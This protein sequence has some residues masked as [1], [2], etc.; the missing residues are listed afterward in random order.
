MSESDLKGYDI[1]PT[2]L[3]PNYPEGYDCSPITSPYATWIDVDGTERNAQHSGIDLGRLN[4]TII[5][6][7]PGRVKAVWRANWGWGLEGA[8]L[9]EHTRENL[10]LKEGAAFYYSAYDHLRFDEIKAFEVGEPIARGEELAH[11]YRPGGFARYL[12]EV[13]FEVWESE[14]DELKWVKNGYGGREWRIEGARLIDPLYMMSLERRPLIGKTVSIL[15]FVKGKDYK[16]FKGFTYP[17]A[18][19]K[20]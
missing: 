15:P 11:V 1:T 13:H 5:A 8:L 16:N 18:C 3:K 14:D 17:L 2:G 6:P 9:I 12:P 19:R 20:K 4:D 7:A 10:N